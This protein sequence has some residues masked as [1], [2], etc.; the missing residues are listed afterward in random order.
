M[1]LRRAKRVR[2]HGAKAP[3]T[4]AAAAVRDRERS[5][6]A[7]RSAPLRLGN[8]RETL[9]NHWQAHRGE[10]AQQRQ[11]G[12]VIARLHLDEDMD[13]RQEEHRQNH[14]AGERV[15]KALGA[16]AWRCQAPDQRAR[17]SD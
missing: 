10:H 13:E 5:L 3:C 15:G 16:P 14:N 9:A 1:E 17:R 4:H 6:L 7:H 2:G 11:V 12:N 8:E